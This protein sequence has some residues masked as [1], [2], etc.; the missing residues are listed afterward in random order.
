VSPII[1]TATVP[2]QERGGRIYQ[3]EAMPKE[4]RYMI[5]ISV[6]NQKG[7]V[8]K[9]TTAVSLAT[10]LAV[11]GYRTLMVDGDPQ[12]NATGHFMEPGQFQRSLFDVIVEIGD[13]QS[14]P[15]REATAQTE[16]K[17]L[18]IVPSTVRLA[19]FDLTPS[20]SIN[21]MREKLQEVHDVYDFVII[22]NPPSLS[23]L[24]MASLIA[25]SH[26]LVPVS[27]APMSHDG[28]DD[29]L[30]TY[31]R[32]STR[33]NKDLQLLGIVTTMFDTR[34][35]V[36]GAMHQQ[37]QE[38]FADLVFDTI[39]HS[40]SKLVES[41]AFKKP[42]QLY[43]PHSRGAQNYAS[44]TDEILTRLGMCKTNDKATSD[45]HERTSVREPAAL[46]N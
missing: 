6:S 32:V 30:N 18:E 8:G 24:L 19:M 22:D 45:T 7:G 14:I 5:V 17:G 31:K 9:T 12:S 39:I 34:L 37:T 36:H 4:A 41:P 38:R 29:L 20:D 44:L 11:R 35:G 25:S 27:S 10:E 13:M 43:A 33:S 42:I 21:I 2:L 28:L 3:P 1:G 26:V 23:Q 15:I 46:K 40:N 16:I